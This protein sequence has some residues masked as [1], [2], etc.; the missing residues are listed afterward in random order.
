MTYGSAR[1]TDRSGAVPRGAE[2][3]FARGMEM[4]ERIPAHLRD[5]EA[6]LG[7]ATTGTVLRATSGYFDVMPHDHDVAPAPMYR[8]RVRDRMRKNFV[9]SESHAHAQ[10]VDDVQRREVVEPVVAG[11]RVRFRP[12][13]V[14]GVQVPAG[15]ID[16]VL[17]R[18]RALTR[19][20]VT[21]GKIPVGQTLVANLDQ[22]VVVASAAHPLPRWGFVDRLLASCAASGFEARVCL[23]KVD[24]GI[25]ADMVTEL[26]W[27][28]RAGYGVHLTSATTM[29]G[30]DELRDAVAGRTTAF[31]GPSG[32][33]KSTLLNAIEPGLALKVGEI[34]RSTNKGKHTTRFAQLFPLENGGFLADTPGLRQLALWD[35]SDSDID[36]LFPEFAAFIGK[37]RYGNCSHVTDDGC[38]IR[39][40]V[41]LGDLSQRRYFSYVKLFT[42]G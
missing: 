5:I 34:S 11:D 33:G 15:V 29:E 17:P 41:E 22:I 9:F 12:S 25:D 14:S 38:A 19:Q 13:H 16:E 28:A 21:D 42:D 3:G 20:A 24:F 6:T 35:V 7:E 4:R 39:T 27:Y 36:Q 8:C 2:P 1:R 30:I 31:T 10:R 37:C 32:V 18:T 40:A 23:N 26:G